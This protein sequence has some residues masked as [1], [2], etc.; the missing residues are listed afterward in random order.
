MTLEAWVQPSTV[1][2]GWR[3]VLYKG[4]DIYFLEATLDSHGVPAGGDTFAGA[5]EWTYSTA[6]L[7]V[8]TWTHLALTYDGVTLILYMNGMQVASLA[9]TG[10]LGTSPNP[11]QIGGDSLF[12]QYFQGTIDEVRVYNRALSALEIQ[13]DMITPIQP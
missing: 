8:N 3:D 1:T 12:G 10:P 2:S 11:L 5:D 9:H 6:P 13:A 7:A 4:N